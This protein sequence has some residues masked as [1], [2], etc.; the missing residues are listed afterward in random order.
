MKIPTFDASNNKKW[1]IKHQLLARLYLLAM[2][3]I[4]PLIYASVILW[5][6][7]DGFSEIPMMAKAIFLPWRV[8]K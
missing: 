6:N 3:P 4:S 1:M 2:L 7:R 8:R 5:N